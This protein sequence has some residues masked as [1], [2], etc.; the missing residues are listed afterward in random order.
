MR[1][2]E[3]GNSNGT[4]EISPDDEVTAGAPGA[5]TITYTAGPAGIE[6]GG[7]VRFEIP[8][9]FTA[10]QL[11]WN[12]DPGYCRAACS[13]PG[14]RLSLALEAP[15][16]RDPERFY[17]V[18]RWG[19]MVYVQVL[20]EKLL[21]G[22]QIELS[23]GFRRH[24]EPGAYAQHFAGTA[25]FTVATD[26]DGRRS[27]RFSGYTLVAQQPVLP[28]VADVPERLHVVAPS[29]VQMGES[30]P[31]R[32]VAEDCERNAC[33]SPGGEFIVDSSDG[34]FLSAGIEPGAWHSSA[35]LRFD[36]PGE[37]MIA[38]VDPR[39]GAAGSSNPIVVTPQ[40]P[41]ERLFWGDIHGHT[42]LSDGLKSPDAYYAFGREQ[43]LLDFCAIA[44]HSQYI[45][46][47]DW[48]EIADAAARH[49]DPGR[50]VTI[51][52]YEVS[53]NAAKPRYGDK[54]VYFPGDD[55]PLLR[56]TDINR[57]EYADLD[58]Y[59]E[60]WKQAGAMVVLHQH[61]GGSESYYD[62]ELVRLAEVYSVWGDSE[63]AEGSRPLLPSLERDY[64]G[65]LAADCL[66]QGWVLGFMA[67]SDDHAGR[68]GRS[69]WLRVR[70]AYPGG[71]AAVWAP[72]LTREAIWDGLYN[73]RCYGTT[74]ARI[75]LEFFVDGEPMGSII[76]NA[77][78]A[79]AHRIGVN[80]CGTARLAAV[81][82]MRGRELVYVHSSYDATCRFT[83]MD[84]PPPGAANYY[85]IRVL[86]ADGEMAWSSPI[87]VS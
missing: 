11:L 37:K 67:A 33:E 76:R 3:I 44:D 69:D 80:V 14:V 41:E 17:Y 48:R 19:R 10:P 18:T 42:G 47:D 73:R 59:T 81:E 55:G 79:Q 62:P 52:G 6:P 64:A 65:M 13:Q 50:Y 70:R 23:Y 16:K 78:F 34:P 29:Y 12:H 87:W 27:A 58:K 86:Q 30:F 43:A 72:E 24:M 77:P 8:Y 53:L 28:V 66:E 61:A 9:G 22:E 56:A 60:P 46:D 32:I 54:C 85:Y 63:T 57:T 74:G 40:Y 75:Y 71:L 51:L 31:V 82:L 4:A 20:E 26:C 21:E 7:S 2:E 39:T 68:P 49:N 45:S 25:E 1:N 84:E 83:H 36:M 38:V 15:V 5:W 35:E